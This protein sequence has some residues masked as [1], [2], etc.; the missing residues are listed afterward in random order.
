MMQAPLGSD[1]STNSKAFGLRT[2]GEKLVEDMMIQ[3]QEILSDAE[4]CDGVNVAY[5][6]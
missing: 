6:G 4:I 5:S 1:R 2:P 3:R